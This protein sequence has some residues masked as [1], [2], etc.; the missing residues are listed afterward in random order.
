MSIAGGPGGYFSFNV[1]GLAALDRSLAQIS[2]EAT[3]KRVIISAMKKALKP[4]AESAKQKVPVDEG[5]L[6]NSIVVSTKIT[7]RQGRGLVKGVPRVFVGSNW[8]SAHLVEFGTGPRVA[9][10]RRSRVLVSQSGQVFG[11]SVDAGNMP[12]MPF[13]RPAFE[14]LQQQVLKKFG[15]EM[16]KNISR[17]AKRLLKQA[18]AGKLSKG[19]RRALGI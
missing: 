10:I 1:D 17:T 5:D 14:S 3:Q 11:T 7:K 9:K 18:K 12:A 16:W 13:L 19:G 15:E 4:V 6:R 2:D 8:P